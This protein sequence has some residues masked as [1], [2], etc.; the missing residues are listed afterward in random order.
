MNIFEFVF[1]FFMIN[2]CI[3]IIAVAVVG[4]LFDKKFDKMKIQ[5]KNLISW[6]DQMTEHYNEHLE[7]CHSNWS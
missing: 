3:T 5:F 1:M 6:S 4:Y 7:D 2:I